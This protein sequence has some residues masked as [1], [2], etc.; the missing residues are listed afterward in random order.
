[1]VTV[2]IDPRYEP[3]I[4][5]D[6]LFWECKKTFR[7]GH[8][9]VIAC[10]PPCTEFSQAMTRRSRELDYADSLV[11]KALEIVYY[12]QPAFW[13]LE[14]PQTG[15][16]KGRPF[17]RGLPYVDVDYCCFSDWGYK[18]GR[19]FGEAQGSGFFKMSYVI[20]TRARICSC[21]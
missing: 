13:F 2:D 11:Q 18:K 14:N 10:S 15:L 8:F 5:A 12:F 19:G 16:L 20:P 4:H 17:M 3:D 1:V 21:M 9:D 6:M 7:P